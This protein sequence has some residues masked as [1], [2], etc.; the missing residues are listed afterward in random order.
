MAADSG[1]WY[2]FRRYLHQLN[3]PDRRSYSVKNS[4][5]VR[6]KQEPF[7]ARFL[8]GGEPPKV[9]TGIKAGVTHKYPSDRDEAQY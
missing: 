8:E 4:D 7:F 5:S 9:K 2:A 6:S 3:R 1:C